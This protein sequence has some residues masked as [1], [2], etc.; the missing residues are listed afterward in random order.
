[1]NPK[2]TIE[3]LLK[4]SDYFKSAYNTSIETQQ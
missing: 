1:M 4:I 2:D 3:G